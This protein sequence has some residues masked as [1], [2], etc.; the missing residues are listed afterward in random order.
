MIVSNNDVQRS[1]YVPFILGLWF[2]SFDPFFAAVCVCNLSIMECSCSWWD[3]GWLSLRCVSISWSPRHPAMFAAVVHTAAAGGHQQSMSEST[4]G[5]LIVVGQVTAP[6]SSGIGTSGRGQE[7][8]A[9]YGCGAVGSWSSHRVL[10]GC[11]N[12]VIEV[13]RLGRRGCGL[14]KATAL[15]KRAF[16]FAAEFSCWKNDKLQQ[17]NVEGS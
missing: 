6:L 15:E 1:R 8:A 10:A 12:A 16:E 17:Q 2:Y 11:R 9:T 5:R 14:I 13:T 7:G 4:A 3:R